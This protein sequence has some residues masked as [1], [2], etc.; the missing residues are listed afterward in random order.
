MCFA[1]APA[2]GSRHRRLI[3]WDGSAGG[4]KVYRHTASSLPL[5]ALCMME[6]MSPSDLSSLASSNH[7]SEKCPLSSARPL[8]FRGS[9]AP[10]SS[11]FWPVGL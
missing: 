2:G 10:R 8:L 4:L 9:S 5:S 3:Q 1:F 6:R 11:I 7:T